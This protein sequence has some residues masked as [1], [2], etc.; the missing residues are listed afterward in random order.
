MPATPPLP[1]SDTPDSENDAAAELA[2]L[3]AEIA[4]H[5]AL[6]HTQDAPEI[7]DAAYD[8]LVRRNSALEAAFPHLVR[9]DSP[10][11]QVGA[12][13]AAHLAKVAHARAMTSLDNALP[14]RT[15]PISSGVFAGFSR[16]PR[17]RRSTSLPNPRSMAYPARCATNAANS[18]RH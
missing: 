16:F 3:A 15:S 17:K 14:T 5:N 7:S 8:A 4:R 10:N 9:S 6:Y 13:P 2:H 12:A 11:T 1:A 18:S